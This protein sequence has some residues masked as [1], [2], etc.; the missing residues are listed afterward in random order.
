MSNVNPEMK[1]IYCDFW[2]KEKV[3]FPPS[4]MAFTS[5]FKC[6]YDSWHIERFIQKQ[7]KPNVLIVN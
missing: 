6:E 1:M 7:S 4:N 2:K 5:I 3:F